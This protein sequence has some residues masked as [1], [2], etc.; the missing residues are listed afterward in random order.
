[1]LMECLLPWLYCLWFYTSES[2]CMYPAYC[3]SDENVY[4]NLDLGDNFKCCL[5]VII[6]EMVATHFSSWLKKQQQKLLL[7]LFLINCAAWICWCDMDRGQL[8][9][10]ALG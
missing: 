5:G 1:M 10:F 9:R 4:M 7:I 3:A 2:L 8:N 6:F